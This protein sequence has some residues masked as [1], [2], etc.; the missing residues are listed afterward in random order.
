MRRVI[1]ILAGIGAGLLLGGCADS[2][3]V[4]TLATH[5][6]VAQ[7]QAARGVEPGYVYYPDYEL[8]YSRNYQQYVFHYNYG[9]VHRTHV[10]EEMT[11]ELANARAVPMNFNDDPVRHHAEVSRLYPSNPQP[12]RFALAASP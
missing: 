9:W 12:A 11:A 7:L 10:P 1:V 6:S 3:R 4:V 5:P 8:Y 2:P